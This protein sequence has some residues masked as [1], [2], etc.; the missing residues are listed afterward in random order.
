MKSSKLRGYRFPLL[1]CLFPPLLLIGCD[2]EVGLEREDCTNR[3]IGEVSAGPDNHHHG[4]SLC[5]EDRGKGTQF[6]MRGIDHAH[7][8]GLSS[9]EVNSIL[10]GHEF[11]KQAPVADGHSHWVSFNGGELEAFRPQSHGA[12]AVKE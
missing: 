3:V 8:M 6:E 12:T 5:E 7:S 2:E 1:V 11:G 10:D 9:M 4:V